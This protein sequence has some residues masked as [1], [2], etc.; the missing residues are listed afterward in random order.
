M[1]YFWNGTT[2]KFVANPLSNSVGSKSYV[3]QAHP[4]YIGGTLYY[5]YQ[6]RSKTG[7][8]VFAGSDEYFQI[9][10]QYDINMTSLGFDDLTVEQMDFYYSLYQDCVNNVDNYIYT[11]Y[12]FTPSEIT[13]NHIVIIALSLGLWYVIFKLIRGLLP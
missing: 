7:E 8:P 9:S 2:F 11:T 1:V 6:L 10:G 13:L 12:D 4:E 3:Y 5:R